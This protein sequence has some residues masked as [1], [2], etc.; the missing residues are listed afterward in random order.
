MPMNAIGIGD[1][2]RVDRVFVGIVEVRLH[3]GEQLGQR[4]ER[5]PASA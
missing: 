4:R 1:A 5:P 2:A 3:G